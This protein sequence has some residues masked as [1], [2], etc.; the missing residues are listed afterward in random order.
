MPSQAVNISGWDTPH[1]RVCPGVSNSAITLQHPNLAHDSYSACW[2]RNSMNAFTWYREPLH[3]RW[4]HPPP[5]ASM[6]CLFCRRRS[7]LARGMRGFHT[8]NCDRP[9]C[10]S[11]THSACCTPFRSKCAS[12]RPGGWSGVKYRP[13]SH[14]TC[15]GAHRRFGCRLFV[16]TL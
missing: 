5:F 12:A 2:C 8:E 7:R 1:D 11:G 6:S 16:A 9:Q 13:A 15:T 14:G 3:M 4:F 10:A